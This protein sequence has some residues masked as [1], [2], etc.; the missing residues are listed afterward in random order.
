MYQKATLDLG[1]LEGGGTMPS[2]SVNIKSNK[3]FYFD[4]NF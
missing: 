4:T 3:Q 2:N 1:W